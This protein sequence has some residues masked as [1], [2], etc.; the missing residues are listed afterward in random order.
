MQSAPTKSLRMLTCKFSATPERSETHEDNESGKANK[1][2]K[3]NNSDSIQDCNMHTLATEIIWT[4][5]TQM[6]KHAFS[7]LGSKSLFSNCISHSFAPRGV[8]YAKF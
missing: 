7:H 8:R 3:S 4:K 6:D 2:E 1:S 5:W